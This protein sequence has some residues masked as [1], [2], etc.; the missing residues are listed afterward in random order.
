MH[1][2]TWKMA[3]IGAGALLGLWWFFCSE[4]AGSYFPIATAYFP[5]QLCPCLCN[6]S[7]SID[8]AAVRYFTTGPGYQQHGQS[9]SNYRSKTRGPQM[10]V[11]MLVTNGLTKPI[12]Q[13]LL[14]DGK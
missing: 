5:T 10:S 1:N 14:A 6:A 4:V 9:S 3:P 12:S 8:G 13:P 7:F 2:I 11:R